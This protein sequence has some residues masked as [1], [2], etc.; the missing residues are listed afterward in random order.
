MP[1]MSVEA[2]LERILGLCRK[3]P[4][5]EVEIDQSLGRALDQ[6]IIATRT[7]PPWNN[8]AMDGYAV[9]HAEVT[10]TPSRLKVSMTVHAGER[11]SRALEV[12]EAA[13]IMTGAPLPDDAD[14]VVMQERTSTP[15]PGFVLI[16]EMPKALQNVRLCGEDIRAGAVLLPAGSPLGV[17]EAGALWAQGLARVQVPR[18]PTV[19]IASSGDE[20]CDV[21]EVP[22]GRTVD[23]NTPVIAQLCRLAGAVPMV[24]GRAPDRIDAMTETFSKGLSSDVLVA[25]SGAS[26]G[27]RDF[28]RDAFKAL[29]IEIDFWKVAMKP[30]KPLAVGVKGQTLVFGLPGNPVSA[31]VTFELFVRPALR[32]LQGLPPAPPLLPGRLAEPVKKPAGLRHFIRARVERRGDALWATPLVVQSSGS[33]ASVVGASHLISLGPDETQVN[34]GS[35]VDLIPLSWGA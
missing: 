28:T 19:A 5:E 17:A 10:S 34:Q 6:P 12:G 11:P 13:R 18:R 22:R 4:G 25:V 14:A 1:L 7:L 23:T 20:L 21:L 33:L 15:E 16:E 24:L 35:A 26:V 27:E 30:G 2:A 29:G 8:S 31:M 9:R 3:L 32:V